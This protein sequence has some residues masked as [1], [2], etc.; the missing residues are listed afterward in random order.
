MAHTFNL[1]RPG[2]KEI[3][4]EF[5]TSL[6]YTRSSGQPGLHNETLS[7]TT[8]TNTQTKGILH[9]EIKNGNLIKMFNR[10]GISQY[11]DTM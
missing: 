9:N 5:K 2:R 4:L 11:C 7:L 3:S 6:L 8:T 1:S 10:H